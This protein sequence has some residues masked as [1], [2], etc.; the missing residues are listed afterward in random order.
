M[1]TLSTLPP[2]DEQESIS[3]NI[4]Y[5]DVLLQSNEPE[6]NEVNETSK[7]SSVS[8]SL[9]KTDKS[10]QTKYDKYTLCAKIENIILKHEIKPL[11]SSQNKDINNAVAHEVVLA[12][13]EKNKYFIVTLPAQ[14]SA[15]YDFLGRIGMNQTVFA[16]WIMFLF[17]HFKD[18]IY[19]MFPE[20]QEFKKTLPKLF[21]TFKN[22]RALVDCTEFKCEMP[23]NYYLYSPYK[24]HCTMKCLIPVNPNG[25]ACFISDLFDGSIRDV[26]M[27]DQLEILQQI[28]PGD[29]LLV[30]KGLNTT[31]FT[32]KASNNIYSTFLGENGCIYKRRSD[33]YRCVQLKQK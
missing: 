16:T 10:T 7:Q 4:S 31:S 18:H 33:A 30:D 29:A 28:N 24:S 12:S 5:D 27:F 8:T 15:L 21:C 13:P 3:F 20:R 17:H 14:F 11:K 9:V 6:V 1:S 25:A 22:I 23:Q 32:Y 19:I 2:H 26:N